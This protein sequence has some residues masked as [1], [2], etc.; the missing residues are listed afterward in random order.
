[1]EFVEY[2]VVRR[3]G[4]GLTPLICEGVSLMIVESESVSCEVVSIW[5]VD[6]VLTSHS[7]DREILSLSGF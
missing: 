7:G 4:V 6:G 5:C 1:M 3:H 2:L